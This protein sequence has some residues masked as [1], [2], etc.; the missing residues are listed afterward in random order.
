MLSFILHKNLSTLGACVV[1][2]VNGERLHLY[3]GQLSIQHYV[4]LGRF[5][6]LE[7]FCIPT[8]APLF[9]STDGSLL[10]P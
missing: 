7:P 2:V 10:L 4:G 8:A 9:S 5:E 1:N 3:R 6:M